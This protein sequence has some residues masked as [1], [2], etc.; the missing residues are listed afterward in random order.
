[1]VK[2][3]IRKEHYFIDAQK[4]AEVDLDKVARQCENQV[5]SYGAD[6]IQKSEIRGR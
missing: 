5:P 3:F 1:M 2:F 4:S 6:K